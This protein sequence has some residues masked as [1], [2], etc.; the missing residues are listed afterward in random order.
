[1]LAMAPRPSQFDYKFLTMT[2]DC[3]LSSVED[4]AVDEQHST[5]YFEASAITNDYLVGVASL[6]TSTTDLNANHSGMS[7]PLRSSCLNLVPDSFS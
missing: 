7:A 5:A 6:N 2:T 4:T 3:H 1:M